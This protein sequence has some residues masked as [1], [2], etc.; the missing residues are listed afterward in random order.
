M[1]KITENTLLG[2]IVANFPGA[3]DYFIK[4]QIDFCCGGDRPLA[5]GIKESGYDKE[6]LLTEINALYKEF[7]NDEKK[8]VNW[9]K[10]DKDKLIDHIMKAHHQFLREELPA[11]SGLIFKLLGVHGENH[12]ELFELHKL[13]AGLKAELESHLVKEETW[14]FPAVK[15]LEKCQNEEERNEL[16]SLIEVLEDEH[17][18]A[19]D[20]LKKLREITNH[21]MPPADGC[22][23]YKMTFDRLRAF[24]KN[25]FEHVHLENNV[26][27]KEY[28]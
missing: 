15:K 24:E 3:G 26:M 11:L 13:F 16:L 4:R 25:M 17:D 20:A 23:T 19:G 18:T 2:D 9:A 8:Y 27:F 1:K 14:L 12:E 5:E 6:T 22:P 28:A 21:Y 10:E 7:I